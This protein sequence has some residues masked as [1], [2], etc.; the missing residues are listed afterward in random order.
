[1]NKEELVEVLREHFPTKGEINLRFNEMEERFDRIDESLEELK[2]SSGALDSI[3]EAHP[4]ERITRLEHHTG[5]PRY[6]H[7]SEDE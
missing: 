5:L 6:A 1:M 3:L 7:S 4:V 2:A